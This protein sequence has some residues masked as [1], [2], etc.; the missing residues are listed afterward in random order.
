VTTRICLPR[1]A[2]DWSGASVGNKEVS[3]DEK[4][5]CAAERLA[6]AVKQ[7]RAEAKLSQ[8]LLAER[9]G[10][11]RQY[12]SHAENPRKNLPSLELIRTLD[13]YF[14]ADGEL[15]ELRKAVLIEQRARRVA[16]GGV[17]RRARAA[18]ADLADEVEP[19]L[20]RLRRVLNAHDL[21][22]EGRMRP[23]D[24]LMQGV[25]RLTDLRL[26]A[27]YAQ[28]AS[29]VP[30][31]LAE[32]LRTGSAGG[33]N[34]RQINGALTLC[35][36]AADGVAFKFGHMDLSARI[37]ELMRR[38]AEDADD[39]LLIGS[40]AYVRTEMFFADGDLGTAAR[41]LTQA[42]DRIPVKAMRNVSGAATYGSLHMRAVVVAARLG[43]ADSVR[44][45]LA[46]AHL[47]A[48]R[49]PEGIYNGTAFGPDSVKIHDLAANV[50]LGDAPTAVERAGSWFPSQQLPAER[51]SH[52][53]IDKSRALVDI[54]LYDQA[55][56]A[57]RTARQMAPQ[58]VRKHPHVRH[59]LA[60]LMG[61]S[62]RKDTELANFASW[63]RLSPQ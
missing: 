58:H 44:D 13:G 46:E 59:S 37:I 9:I 10:Y 62:L 11:T 17:E 60:T 8:S 25:A 31:L 51:R 7:R 19:D 27:R 34:R 42:A 16:A 56:D 4:S 35:Y 50:D 1:F 22:E 33:T 55:H 15:L 28:L 40:V 41:L 63:V 32:I 49:V 36:R 52:Y 57:L 21:P 18:A 20:V 43:E 12:V 38:S 45:H 14:G 3:N 54:G 24:Q 53:L 5:P 30:D 23:V 6:A 26:Q 2:K 61:T 29:E 47:M 48:D 39:E